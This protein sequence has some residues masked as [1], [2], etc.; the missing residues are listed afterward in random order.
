[1]LVK[2]INTQLNSQG[3]DSSIAKMPVPL[4][5]GKGAGKMAQL[6]KELA[7]KP[8][9]LSSIPRSHMERR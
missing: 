3:P 1:M 4:K 7:A 5:Q 6:V 2:T 9:N 8:H